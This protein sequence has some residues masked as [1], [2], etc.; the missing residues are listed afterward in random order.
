[1][2]KK[3]ICALFVF[4]SSNVSAD[5]VTKSNS[6]VLT[7][8]S[9]TSADNN[10]TFIFTLSPAWPECPNGFWFSMSDPGFAGNVSM[11][12]SAHKAQTSLYIAADTS[13]QW[14]SAQPISI[15]FSC[16]P[17]FIFTQ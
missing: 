12:I 13:L 15:P 2:F 9:F 5:I 14:S 4:V 1:M 17:I 11:L 7:V 3:I 8:G 16:K 10:G 6:K